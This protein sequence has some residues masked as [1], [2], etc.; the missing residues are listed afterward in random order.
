RAVSD[1]R[2]RPTDDVEQRLGVPV[3][4]MLPRV[5]DLTGDH[6]LVDVDATKSDRRGGFAVREALR[7]LRTNLQFMDVDH[8]PRI[9]VVTSA[10]PGEGKSTVAA[11]LAMTL[12]A[13]GS[14]VVLIDGDLRRPTVSKTLGLSGGAGVTDVLA[15]R[16][17]VEDVAQRVPNSSLIVLTAGTI[18]PNP[19]EVLGSERMHQLLRDLAVHATVIVDAPPLLPVTDGAVLT[20]QAD[21]ALLVVSAGKTTYDVVERALGALEK[22]RGRMLGVVLNRVPASGVDSSVYAYGYKTSPE[23]EQR[24]RR[25]RRGG[26]TS[27]PASAVDDSA[28]LVA[29]EPDESPA[30]EV[31]ETVPPSAP[32]RPAKKAT[33]GR[34]AAATRHGDDVD[35]SE[36]DKFFR[37]VSADP[38]P[39]PWRPPAQ[40]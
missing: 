31:T 29:V 19:S 40:D 15:G 33:S 7:V 34:P 18:P 12:A 25:G 39:S 8:P 22:V 24:R 26:D 27:D 5:D 14:S 37:A 4:G 17:A 20:H 36:L 1:R 10:L 28:S 9:I 6:R 38:A 21:G 3:V 16:A 13:A 32:R 30:A 2:I 23:S 11:N 35:P